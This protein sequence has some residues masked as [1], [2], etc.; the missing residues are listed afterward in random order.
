LAYG[1]GYAIISATYDKFPRR[2]EL[3]PFDLQVLFG[4]VIA[5]CVVASL[6]GIRKALKVEASEALGG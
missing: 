6:I 5:I 3:V 1:V 2:V 4:I